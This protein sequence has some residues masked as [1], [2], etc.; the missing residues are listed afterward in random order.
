MPQTKGNQEFI[1][2]ASNADMT[3][4]RSIQ[5]L[6]DLEG[7]GFTGLLDVY[8][9]LGIVEMA[10]KQLRARIGRRFSVKMRKPLRKSEI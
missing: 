7:I 1:A 9:D 6:R 3:L 2:T 10:V 5:T 8:Q 4:R